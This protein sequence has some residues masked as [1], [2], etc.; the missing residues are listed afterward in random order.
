MTYGRLDFDP[1]PNSRM[2]KDSKEKTRRTDGDSM[3]Y[4]M[5]T[6]EAW[7]G[8]REWTAVNAALAPEMFE[9][10]VQLARHL[11]TS[12]A[13]VIRWALR[14]YLARNPTETHQS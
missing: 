2:I 3:E 12:R 11:Q 9:Q 10:L 4:G 14:E 1:G 8:K 5:D 13:C 6:D 7:V